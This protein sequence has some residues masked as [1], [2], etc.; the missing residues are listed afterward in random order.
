VPRGPILAAIILTLSLILNVMFMS[1]PNFGSL[2][3]DLSHPA[4][5]RM[6]T[7]PLAIFFGVMLLIYAGI[8]ALL[9][10]LVRLLPHP[11][12]VPPSVIIFA[13]FWAY[14]ALSLGGLLIPKNGG[15]T[16]L[17]HEPFTELFWH[18]VL[19][20]ALFLTSL[21]IILLDAVR[22]RFKRPPP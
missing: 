9:L 6:G 4:E 7:A 16:W 21:A 11:W 20:P 12:H 19:T 15:A 17:W 3:V 18:P 13:A 1:W 2:F 10:T 8:M 14:G 22:L 5:A